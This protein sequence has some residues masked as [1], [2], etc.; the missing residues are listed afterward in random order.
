MAALTAP[1]SRL[2]STRSVSSRARASRNRSCA[3][4]AAA[5]G[6]ANS[7]AAETAPT[8]TT[9][10]RGTS[11]TIRVNLS[12]LRIDF[13]EILLVHQDLPRLAPHPGRHETVH[14]HHVDQTGCAAETDAQP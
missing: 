3:E 4:S 9:N 6:R 11:A 1:G 13:A 7:T 10:R 14:L 5:Q 2:A 8:A 12:E